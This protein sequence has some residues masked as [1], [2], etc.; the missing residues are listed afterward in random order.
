MFAVGGSHKRFAP[1]TEQVVGSH[2]PQARA[3][4]S[5]YDHASALRRD[6]T[7]SVGRKL[8]RDLL[9]GIAHR[10]A[11]RRT[12][13]AA[14][15]CGNNWRGLPPPQRTAASL[16]HRLLPLAGSRGTGSRATDDGWRVMLPEMLQ[17][18]F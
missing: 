3:C 8:Q 10:H 13:L 18:F 5:P 17:G 16:A 11:L 4:D 1:Q 14:P 6:A 7:V 12:E 15:G 9:Y 2:Q